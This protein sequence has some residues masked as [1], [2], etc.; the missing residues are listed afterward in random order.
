[1]EMREILGLI[2]D[3]VTIATPIVAYIRK[4]AKNHSNADKSGLN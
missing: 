4:T 3:L 2:A 1:M